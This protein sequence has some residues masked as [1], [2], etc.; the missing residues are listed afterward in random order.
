MHIDLSVIA[1]QLFDII[2]TIN[3]ITIISFTDIIPLRSQLGFEIYPNC[4][5]SWKKSTGEVYCVHSNEWENSS[6]NS[7]FCHAVAW[8]FRRDRWKTSHGSQVIFF[9]AG[10]PMPTETDPIKSGYR[11]PWLNLCTLISSKHFVQYHVHTYPVCVLDAVSRC[12]K[13][14]V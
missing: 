5:I 12:C 14:H 11:P 6:V 8:I 7:S 13:R 9:K 2:W 10:N 1:T 3:I 4:T